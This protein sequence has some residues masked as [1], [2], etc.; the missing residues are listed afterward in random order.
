MSIVIIDYKGGN[1]QSVKF[2]LERLGV[3]ATLTTR[4]SS[5]EKGR[6]APPCAS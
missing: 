3:E 1:V 2:A 5:R 4:S 6:P